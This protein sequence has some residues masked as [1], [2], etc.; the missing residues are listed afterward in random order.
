MS[1]SHSAVHSLNK[2]RD[3]SA[4]NLL[5]V[6]VFFFFQLIKH[7]QSSFTAATIML[8]SVMFQLSFAATFNKHKRKYSSVVYFFVA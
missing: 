4:S 3:I 7:A 2:G 6:G 8:K 5:F 1:D